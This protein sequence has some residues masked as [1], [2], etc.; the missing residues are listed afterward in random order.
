[1]DYLS[2][3][4]PYI[5]N[6]K[7]RD[8]FKGLLKETGLQ[9]GF[10][11]PEQIMSGRLAGC[12]I[13]ILPAASALSDDLIVRIAEFVKA[14]GTVVA[15]LRVGLYSE[16]GRLMLSR[17]PLESVFGLKHVGA[18]YATDE[19][20][21]AFSGDFASVPAGSGIDKPVCREGLQLAGGT[22]HAR[23][24]DGTPAMVVN[25]VGKGR[26]VYL[27]FLPGFGPASQALMNRVLD[28]AGVERPVRL[29]KDGKPAFGYE[30][31]RFERGSVQYLG[32]LRDMPPLPKGERAS[33]G[34][35]VSRN[36][37]VEKETISIQLSAPVHVYDVRAGKYL[38]CVGA[39][40][41][42]LAPSTAGVY[43]LLPYAVQQV[44]VS[45]VKP[46]YR[47]GDVVRA[48]IAV[49]PVEGSCGNHVLRIEVLGPSGEMARPYTRNV[50]AEGGRLTLSLPLALNEAPGEWKM[51]A[52]DMASKA[53]ASVRFKI[54]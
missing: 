23:Y 1:M 43:A 13:L 17:P 7:S 45:G 22:A 44:T 4:N 53:A 27:N 18:K 26:A 25:T 41:V 29:L 3:A 52:T 38:G 12:R 21:L 28:M 34:T 51:T 20:V 9:P 39:F 6:Y 48:E 54:Q 47:P 46:E 24:P 50:L 30:C 31:Y 10:L 36:A 40:A 32:I 37:L 42:D 16:H 2:P 33:M 15:D 19:A 35:F 11:A 5:L 14:G 49:R 8:N